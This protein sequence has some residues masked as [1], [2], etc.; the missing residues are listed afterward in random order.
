MCDEAKGCPDGYEAFACQCTPIYSE[1]K[2]TNSIVAY[3]CARMANRKLTTGSKAAMC[4]DACSAQVTAPEDEDP[5]AWVSPCACNQTHGYMYFDPVS[6][7]EAF[8]A[9][10]APNITNGMLDLE[11]FYGMRGHPK[12]ALLYGKAWEMG[13]H[14]GLQ[15]V[16]N[17]Y[18]DLVELV[19]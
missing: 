11:A 18:D 10:Y 6:W 17:Y 5:V 3:D 13:H 14:A 12:A 9:T 1:R 7:L 2:L 19:K 16:A 8:N 4:Y 15:E